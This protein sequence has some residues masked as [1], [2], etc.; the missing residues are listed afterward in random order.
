MCRRSKQTEFAVM[1]FSTGHYQDQSASVEKARE[2][3][4]AIGKENI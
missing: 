2:G 3:A 1:I 4:M